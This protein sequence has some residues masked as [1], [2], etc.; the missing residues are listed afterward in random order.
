MLRRY[1]ATGPHAGRDA[2]ARAR[3]LEAAGIADANAINKIADG[4][5]HV[6]DLIASR[7]RR[8]RHQRCQGPARNLRRLQDSPRGGRSEHC[9]FDESGYGAGAGGGARKH[10]RAAAEPARV[11]RG[12]SDDRRV[13]GRIAGRAARLRHRRQRQHAGGRQQF[14]HRRAARSRRGCFR[15]RG[16]RSASSSATHGRTPA[17]RSTGLF[18]WIDRTFPPEDERAFVAPLRDIELLARIGWQAPLPEATSTKPACSTSKTFPTS[19]RSARARAGGDRAV[20]RLPALVRARRVRVEREAALRVGLPRASVRPARTVAKRRRTRNGI[21]KRFRRSRTSRPRCWKRAALKSCSVST[22][23]TRATARKAINVVAR[24]RSGAARTW[25]CGPSGG[26]T[27]LRETDACGMTNRAIRRAVDRLRAALRGRYVA[28]QV[29][30]PDRRRSGDRRETRQSAPRAARRLSRAHSRRPTAPSRAESRG[31]ARAYP[32]GAGARANGRLR[33]G[34]LRNERHRR[35]LRPRAHAAR[36]DRRSARATRR[37][38]R[39]ADAA[40]RS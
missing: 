14:R 31:G 29:L 18:D 26:F 11:P 19:R 2:R 6:L 9:V 39:R 23:S 10:G 40:R 1:A 33:L 27:V 36:H 34:A 7:A 15:W 20:R 12:A 32:F 5:P 28:R 16:R 17:S 13:D 35:R 22:P 37:N 38:S 4:S 24:G 8:P 25:R 21:S 3:V 30:R